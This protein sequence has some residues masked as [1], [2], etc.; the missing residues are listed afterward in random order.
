MC[1]D[2]I[3][4]RISFAILVPFV[5]FEVSDGRNLSIVN[6]KRFMPFAKLRGQGRSNELSVLR[7]VFIVLIIFGFF[8]ID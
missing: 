3:F 5:C 6:I 1:G 8:L 7:D 2:G 4:D